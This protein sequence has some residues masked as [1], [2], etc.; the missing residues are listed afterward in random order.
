MQVE[1]HF[2]NTHQKINA[3]IYFNDHQRDMV[4]LHFGFLEPER[5][6]G[7]TKPQE[8]WDKYYRD[9]AAKFVQPILG[10]ECST[11]DNALRFKCDLEG[12][13]KMAAYEIGI[14]K[15]IEIQIKKTSKFEQI[16]ARIAGEA[17]GCSPTTKVAIFYNAEWWSV[18][19]TAITKGV[20]GHGN[21]AQ[22]Y[23][24]YFVFGEEKV[25]ADAKN[26]VKVEYRIG[27]QYADIHGLHYYKIGLNKAMRLHLR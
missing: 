10:Q 1:E 17:D 27:M 20:H 9:K 5:E 4:L 3:M 23:S 18:E 19:P 16:E 11:Y 25:L 15:T 8:Y 6:H 21:V 2:F 12:V 7:T 14:P 13:T 24:P 26:F 22:G